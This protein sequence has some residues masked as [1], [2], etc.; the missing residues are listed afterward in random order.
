[1]LFIML[2]VNR[3][4]F[5]EM[6]KSINDMIVPKL[7]IGLL[8]L[9]NHNHL[10]MY[11]HF[12]LIIGKNKCTKFLVNKQVIQSLLHGY[13][14]IHILEVIPAVFFQLSSNVRIHNLDLFNTN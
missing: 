5:W 3:Y 4:T 10:C 6:E 7:E 9:N 12:H 8:M 11:T 2:F 13:G 1:M 14:I